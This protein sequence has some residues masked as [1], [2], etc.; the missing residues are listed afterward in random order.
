MLETAMVTIATR[1]MIP[2]MVGK[3]LVWM[4]LVKWERVEVETFLSS[5]AKEV[6]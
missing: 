6:K 1:M 4:L 3:R 2:V 5:R